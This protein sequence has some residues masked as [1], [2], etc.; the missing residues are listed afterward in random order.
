MTP[1]ELEEHQSKNLCFFCYD[2]FSFGHNCPQRQKMQVFFMEM[3][4]LILAQGGDTETVEEKPTKKEEN[5]ASTSLNSLLGNVENGTGTM[6][7]KDTTGQKTLHILID[8]GSSH[9]FLN[10]KF[11]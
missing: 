7:V 11:S 4:D 5:E 6:R 8:M 3:K 1:A 2:K 10:D 9:S